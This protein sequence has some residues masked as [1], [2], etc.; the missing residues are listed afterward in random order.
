[1]TDDQWDM[2]FLTRLARQY[3]AMTNVKDS[4]L[5]FRPIGSST[6]ASGKALPSIEL[7]CRSGDRH[8]YHIAERKNHA[9]VRAFYYSTDRA[10]R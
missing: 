1:M 8:R 4:H 2:S 6:T 5:L 3:D 10:K 7:T 9:G